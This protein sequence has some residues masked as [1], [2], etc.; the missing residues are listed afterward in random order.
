MEVLSSIPFCVPCEPDEWQQ[1]SL[2]QAYPCYRL[3]ER[4]S[5]LLLVSSDDCHLDLDPSALERDSR[6]LPYPRLVS[7]VQSLIETGDRGSL[8]AIIDAQNLTTEWGE[9]HLDLQGPQDLAWAQRVNRKIER[10]KLANEDFIRVTEVPFE[11]ADLWRTMA[12][13]RQ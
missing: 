2:A 13:K 7:M 10:L 9:H 5:R 3:G 11:K 6:G 12:E 1:Y 8:E 4:D